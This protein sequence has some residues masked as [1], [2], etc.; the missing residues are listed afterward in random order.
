MDLR[1]ILDRFDSGTRQ[2]ILSAVRGEVDPV[3]ADR[4]A[5]RAR[6]THAETEA[7]EL[8]AELAETQLRASETAD[9]ER[10][11][12]AADDWAHVAERA[13]TAEAMP[14]TVGRLARYPNHDRVR[15][16]RAVEASRH[17]GF[18]VREERVDEWVSAGFIGTDGRGNAKAGAVEA[19]GATLT[20]DEIERVRL[21]ERAA[22]AKAEG[23]LSASTGVLTSLAHA[24]K[25]GDLIEAGELL[26]IAEAPRCRAI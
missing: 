22:I 20:P 24:L 3:E 10:T 2:S 9:V 25:A 4:D 18:P 14:E 11:E 1:T 12:T 21:S 7:A 19:F 6:L 17:F 26:A 16:L 23:R 5:L 8:R 13:L 15:E